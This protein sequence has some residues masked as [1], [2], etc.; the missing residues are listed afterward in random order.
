MSLEASEVLQ[1]LL[2]SV[3]TLQQSDRLEDGVVE[4]LPL[5]APLVHAEAIWIYRI[6]PKNEEEVLL[7]RRL[8]REDGHW[9]A[10]E[11]AADVNWAEQLSPLSETATYQ[12]IPTSNTAH[13]LN[14][15]PFRVKGKALGFFVWE[16]ALT[17]SSEITEAFDRISPYLQGLCIAVDRCMQEKKIK[18]QRDY[19]RKIIDNIPGLVFS[20]DIE[21]RF[22]LVNKR[23]AEIY[24]VPIKALIGKKD[25][26]FN[27]YPEEVKRYRAEDL[28][29]LEEGAPVWLPEDRIITPE[30]KE[31]F[32]QTLK[33]P[34]SSEKDDGLNDV[35]GLALDI[36]AWRK[37][38]EKEE[39]SRERYLNFLTHAEEGIYYVKCDPPVPVKDTPVEQQVELYY[40]SAEIAECNKAMANM[41]GFDKPEDFIG[42]KI[43]DLHQ[44]NGYEQN[45]ASSIALFRNGVRE[46][47]VET[48]EI[49][50]DGEE[51]WFIN[52]AVGIFE[53]GLLVGI[54]GG[55]HEITERKRMEFS[56][57]EQREELNFILEGA[58][59]ATWYWDVPNQIAKFNEHFWQLLGYDASEAPTNPKEFNN[60]IHPD[61]L[62]LFIAKATKHLELKNDAK[63][64]EH[65]MRLLAKN[66]SYKWVLNRG[67]ALV[68]NAEGFP[69]QGSGIFVDITDRKHTELAL[70]ESQQRTKL[71]LDAAKL[72]LWEWNAQTDECFYNRHWG[73]MLGYTPEEIAPVGATFFDLIHPEDEPLLTQALNDQIAGKTEFFE[74]EIR[75]RTKS[76]KWKW[77]HD[78][79][80]VMNRDEAGNAVMVAGVHIDID[81]RKS[82]ERVLAEREAFFRTL[83]EDSPL[84]ILFCSI[85]GKIAETN[86]KAAK[87]LGYDRTELIGTSLNQFSHERQFFEGL[88]SELLSDSTNYNFERQLQHKGGKD[89]WSN[90]LLN[91]IKDENG[92][93][94]SII[95]S[96]E[97]ISSRIEAQQALVESE[98]LK[99]AILDALPDLKF[100]ID[101]DQRFVSFFAPKG[102]G[103]ALI[104]P[105]E[106][107]LGKKV[108]E[109]LP[110]HI[111]QGLKVNLK[112]ALESQTVESFE[113]PMFID[114]NMRHYE[115]RVNGI[116]ETEAIVVVRDVTDLK[117]AQQALQ[118]KLRELDHNNEKLTRYVNSNLQLE[119]FAHTVSHDLREPVRTMNSFA[120]L[121]KRRYEDNLDEDANAYLEFISKSAVHM[122]KLIEDLLEFARFT[123]SDEHGFEQVDLNDLL[124]TVQQSL[125]GL[126]KD[127][128]AEV[129]MAQTLPVVNGNPTK[130]GQLFQNL[131]SNGIKFQQKGILPVVTLEVQDEGDFW[132]FSV[133]DNG[134]GID[135]D[136]HGQIFQLFRRLHSKKIYPGSGIGLALCKR[137]VEQHGGDI[138]VESESGKGSRFIFT[139]H[140][141]F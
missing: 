31:V 94:E 1:T 101:K 132:Q 43:S 13:Q 87:I 61:D 104:L 33:M 18:V 136:H 50:P 93:P 34:V 78:K 75:L 44:G 137:V 27:P 108:E 84:G 48:H 80:Q 45:Y 115:A 74:V 64:F 23:V 62:P 57:R 119:N 25:S 85:D 83:F 67:R 116:N 128:N 96:I 73:E 26:D 99:R 86:E 14:A 98:D 102:D 89:I 97:D 107:F 71:V 140:K 79:G 60:L 76:G 127:K 122:N 17:S 141:N 103:P 105:P 56:L 138:W 16:T 51:R 118:N 38:K 40:Q 8:Y 7:V 22:V 6:H 2:K 42:T 88:M 72:G 49:A 53:E 112:K 47:N 54:W 46:R 114:G 21:G 106:Q 20:K 37:I 36:S 131:I 3:L 39:Q 4:T 41:Y 35:L 81:F 11:Q 139:I 66:G 15:A 52:H 9:K 59:V 124:A 117:I 30:G 77:I 111:A 121:L 32:L 55:Q 133:Q 5:I 63:V 82:A 69:V 109:V 120:Q 126:I 10:D 95:C 19:L 110:P 113:Y 29:V 130:L 70:S 129:L 24:G 135:K 92:Q 100:R 125:R 68:W 91:I 90:L 28:R 123:N 58:K 65:E 134:I 12:E